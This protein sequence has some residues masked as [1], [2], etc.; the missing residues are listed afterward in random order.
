MV[1]S[2]DLGFA[3]TPSCR[4]RPAGVSVPLFSSL[5]VTSLFLVR[6]CC[7]LMW[8]TQWKQRRQRSRGGLSGDRWMP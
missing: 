1:L 3:T 4:K 2:D 8:I 7:S 6:G 5:L